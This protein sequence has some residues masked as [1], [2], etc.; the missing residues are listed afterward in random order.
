[1]S[2]PVDD[3]G[4]IAGREITPLIK[5]LI[6]GQALLG[7]TSQTL[8]AMPYTSAIVELA[9]F[10]PRKPDHNRDVMTGVRNNPQGLFNTKL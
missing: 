6:I 1:M 7:I 5:H 10:P 4:G 9:L 8:A 2:L 3:A